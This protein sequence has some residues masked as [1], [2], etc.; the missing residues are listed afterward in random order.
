MI[1]TFT[2]LILASAHAS[3]IGPAPNAPQE[4]PRSGVC[5]AVLVG[6]TE[7]PG[8]EEELVRQGH[9]DRYAREIRLEGPGHDVLDMQRVLVDVL[10]AR[11]EDLCTLT[12]WPADEAIRPTRANIVRALEDLAAASHDGDLAVVYLAGHGTQI[13]DQNGDE[14]DGL[15]ECFLPADLASWDPKAK[16]LPGAL[17]D[18][19]L[20]PLIAAIRKNGAR[21]WLVVDACYS[22][23]ML[24][25]GSDG[26][27]ERALR[28]EDLGVPQV[29]SPPNAAGDEVG[30]EALQDGVTAMYAVTS[31]MRAVEAKMPIG[32]KDYHGVFT[33]HLTR[34]LAHSGPG[35]T[36][37]ELWQQVIAALNNDGRGHLRPTIDGERSRTILAGARSGMRLQLGR[38]GQS[39]YVDGGAMHGLHPGDQLEVFARGHRDS[40]QHRLGRIEVVAAEPTRSTVKPAAT[41]GLAATA[42]PKDGDLLPVSLTRTSI[43]LRQ[44]RLHLRGPDGSDRPVAELPPTLRTMWRENP[45]LAR[46]AG[47]VEA[48]ERADAA[49]RLA[50]DGGGH[51]EFTGDTVTPAL[52]FGPDQLAEL[53]YRVY[54]VR[55]LRQITGDALL[56]R[57]PAGLTVRC[58]LLPGDDPSVPG[59]ALRQGQMI[60]PGTLARIVVENRSN[61]SWDV[62]VFSLDSNLDLTM[63]LPEAGAAPTIG[64][65]DRALSSRVV[66]FNDRTIG[67]EQILAFAVPTDTISLAALAQNARD[68]QATT[69]GG[70]GPGGLFGEILRGSGSQTR[71]VDPVEEQLAGSCSIAYE[72]GWGTRIATMPPAVS[73]APHFL[74]ADV[75]LRASYQRDERGSWLPAADTARSRQLGDIYGRL[76]PAVVAVR[77]RGGYGT[78]FLIDRERG[79]IVTNHHVVDSAVCYSTRGRWLHQVLVG[80]LDP[81]GCMRLSRTDLQAEVILADKHRDL[82]L[83]QVQGSL[84]WLKDRPVL[85]VTDQHPR[86]SLE[87]AILGHPSSGML[88]SF[89]DGRVSQIG[90]FPN[91]RVEAIVRASS[92]SAAERQEAAAE[93][94]QQQ[95]LRILMSTCG[96]NHGDSGGPLVDASGNLIGV[97]FAVP[98][99]TE[100]KEFTY[101][102]HPDELRAF[103][104]SQPGPEESLPPQPPDLWSLGAEVGW[105]G[106]TEEMC[107]I[108]IGRTEGSSQTILFDFDGDSNLDGAAKDLGSAAAGLRATLAK[109]TE[110]SLDFEL[111]ILQTATDLTVGYDTDGNRSFDLIL[112]DLDLD[113]RADARFQ[114]RGTTWSYEADS[115]EPSLRLGNLGAD[116]DNTRSKAYRYAARTLQRALK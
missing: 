4:P 32:S 18:D 9:A 105:Q 112:V 3:C 61:K 68:V 85:A 28:S 104:A 12:G 94:A 56:G 116:Y 41:D 81:E 36:Y 7:Y 108:L 89:R 77:N 42:W 57:L 114:L 10:E 96:A 8:L 65:G 111:A 13:P 23:T 110:G 93:L 50:A 107:G 5:R 84:D 22:G 78:G 39:L 83:L 92:L 33:W 113:G 14:P 98:S 115:G 88:W 73:T 62:Y 26:E 17:L 24:R 71:G 63:L 53:I 100:D 66:R 30:L 55:S 64:F 43:E 11:P 79:L 44:L 1:A 35:V 27:R 54:R 72:V 86:P 101:H 6:V 76:A 60:R 97:T 49:V 48:G 19:D 67:A 34:Q 91:D 99:R 29:L 58:E 80:D 38:R 21:V 25:G 15:D 51:L 69:R 37:E 90:S 109:T 95:P 102:L 31:R 59:V 16:R 47:W 87:C 40:E 82:A 20:G 52:P 75:Q 46:Q 70:S 74:A 103:L 45:E 2:L 106:P